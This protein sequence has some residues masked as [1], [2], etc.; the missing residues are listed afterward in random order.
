M[1][2]CGKSSN[3]NDLSEN[4]AWKV[5]L[6]AGIPNTVGRKVPRSRPS[7]SGAGA[8]WK[9]RLRKKV[10]LP[11]TKLLAVLAQLDDGNV[12]ANL[13]ALSYE[14][15]ETFICNLKLKAA[16]IRSLRL[17][18][19]PRG[20]GWSQYEYHALQ[21]QRAK[22]DFL[23]HTDEHLEGVHTVSE[24]M[25]HKRLRFRLAAALKDILAN[26]KIEEL[27]F[28]M[29][30][31]HNAY[32]A[33]SCGLARNSSIK[34]LSFAGSHLGDQAL[35]MMQSG[36]IANSSLEELDLTACEVSDMGANKIAAIITSHAQ[37]RLNLAFHWQL[38][39][40]PDASLDNTT[41]QVL[42]QRALRSVAKEVDL[43]CGGLRHIELAENKIT[44]SGAKV[45]CAALSF[46]RRLVLLSLRACLLTSDIESLFIELMR[47][48]RALLRVDLRQNL[49]PGMGILKLRRPH[50]MPVFRPALGFTQT[51]LTPLSPAL[52]QSSR[53]FWE[54]LQSAPSTAA[55]SLGLPSP[56]G[57]LPGSP[58]LKKAGEDYL[59]KAAVREQRLKRQIFKAGR[60]DP[61]LVSLAI[62]SEM[63][64][65]G[66]TTSS[67]H[68]ATSPFT[69]TKSTSGCIEPQGL[70][71]KD[72][73]GETQQL[74]EK[75][76][77]ADEPHRDAST[78][79]GT[80]LISLPSTPQV[81]RFF[82]LSERESSDRHDTTAKSDTKVFA[83][84]GNRPKKSK[85][86]QKGQK[87]QG[88]V[89]E[90][91]TLTPKLLRIT[92]QSRT[93]N[94]KR[95]ELIPADSPV[96]PEMMDVKA[97][98][99]EL[100]Q[101]FRHLEV[102]VSSLE[103]LQ[104]L[105]AEIPSSF[106]PNQKQR[107]TKAVNRHTFAHTNSLLG[108]S[109]DDYR[110]SASCVKIQSN[111]KTCPT[112]IAG[113]NKGSDLIS[114]GSSS[115]HDEAGSAMALEVSSQVNDLT[116]W[117]HGCVLLGDPE[118]APEQKQEKVL[119]A[120]PNMLN[121]KGDACSWERSE[122]CFVPAS[123][124]SRSPTSPRRDKMLSQLTRW[125][126]VCDDALSKDSA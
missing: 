10:K 78:H 82:A 89:P 83:K 69:S 46:D 97:E 7:S 109:A 49:D 118:G 28:G 121:K 34:K 106:F 88:P 47:D 79:A 116:M 92:A 108:V 68:A 84:S 44:D 18:V 48:H 4:L 3:L 95:G 98:I 75:L 85:S 31:A 55:G 87:K 42:H 5:W 104:E 53:P 20:V 8:A 19:M 123:H 30:M 51:F 63:V 43:E 71:V 1:E 61:D 24:M 72:P 111:A 73:D 62:P 102:E 38:R 33:L 107:T 80:L 99:Y 67:H 22:K 17:K 101:M 70:A 100:A 11:A 57:S 64:L 124:M 6:P 54:L 2:G 9:E 103:F 126:D 21:D 29:R 26:N 125:L 15:I 14:E 16:N 50:Q 115:R 45:M 91:S 66:H 39:E 37:R 60:D 65:D 77:C 112:S 122:S 117:S 56:F 40:Y 74:D 23:Y 113:D 96:T 25:Q 90:V 36:L 110:S 58:A 13:S 119:E 105:R 12:E 76:Q 59:L 120:L 114:S 27:E 35:E 41:A 86:L 93:T 81:S 32:K 94:S 52:T